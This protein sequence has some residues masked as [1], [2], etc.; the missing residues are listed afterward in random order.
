MGGYKGRA[1]Y[2]MQDCVDQCD[3]SAQA[4]PCYCGEPNCKGYIG[5][6]SKSSQRTMDIELGGFK[7][8]A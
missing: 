2:G 8:S 3:C 7:N 5:G 4:Q 6:D 1:E